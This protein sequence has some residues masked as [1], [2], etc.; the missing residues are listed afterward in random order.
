MSRCTGGLLHGEKV[1]DTEFVF[2]VNCAFEVI[3]QRGR[4][5]GALVAPARCYEVISE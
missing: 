4:L 1:R 2:T 3:W 5:T